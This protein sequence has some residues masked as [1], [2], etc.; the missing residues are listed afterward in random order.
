MTIGGGHRRVGGVHISGLQNTSYL[1]Q[2]PRSSYT[3]LNTSPS[4]TVCFTATGQ[5]C[6]MH[7]ASVTVTEGNKLLYLF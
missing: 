6:G 2:H 3:T 1:A 4:L 5:F 7:G